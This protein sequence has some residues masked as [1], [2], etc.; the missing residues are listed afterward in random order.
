MFKITTSLL[1]AQVSTI[2]HR[3]V[4]QQMPN[5]K[6]VPRTFGGKFGV[7]FVLNQQLD[8]DRMVVDF[9]TTV[10]DQL[11]IHTNKFNS[12][13]ASLVK[14]AQLHSIEVFVYETEHDWRDL[15]KKH[16][17]SRSMLRQLLAPHTD[18]WFHDYFSRKMAIWLEL[19]YKHN[20]DQLS[21]KAR[22]YLISNITGHHTDDDFILF[23]MIVGEAPPTAK[24]TRDFVLLLDQFE[25]HNL[26]DF[27]DLAAF[28]SHKWK[29]HQ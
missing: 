4:L 11:H 8:N 1:D 28:L 24:D 14:Y 21:E 16:V 12:T 9:P 13:F 23:N 22:K 18:K 2:S 29:V 27:D 26:D 15:S 19:L 20:V 10:I 3:L 5:N 17:M 6:F 25:E 7:T